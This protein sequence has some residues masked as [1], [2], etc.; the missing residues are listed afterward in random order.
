MEETDFEV[1]LRL[2]KEANIYFVE[3]NKTIITNTDVD[4]KEG[5][6]IPSNKVTVFEFEGDGSMRHATCYE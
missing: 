2:L 6:L 3:Q 5:K 4:V 1:V